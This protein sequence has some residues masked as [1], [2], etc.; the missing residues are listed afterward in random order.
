[1]TL[2]H[3]APR[4]ALL[5]LC[6]LAGGCAV[7][8]AYHRPDI[9]L[10]GPYRSVAPSITAGAPSLDTWWRGFDDPML[11]TV[12]ERA[13]AENLDIAQA[14]ARVLMSRAQAKA[15]GAALFP[16]GAF[17]AQGQSARQSLESPIGTIGR[18]L[19]GFKRDN[20]IADFGVGASWDP[21]LFGGL[22]RG[23]AA[24]RA[25]AG[26]EAAR[27]EAVRLAVVADTADA[28]IQVRAFQARLGVVA[29][30]EAT[31]GDLVELL[32]KQAG[33]GV[34]PERELRQTQA[35]LEGVRASIPPLKTGLEI[36]LNRLDVLMGARPGTW[37]EQLTKVA[38]IPSPPGLALGDGPADLLRRRP[39]IL[40]AEQR[41]VATNARIGQAMA[42]YYPKVT[43]SGLL[44]MESLDAS[45]LFTPDAIQAVGSGALKW[46][47]FDFGRVDAEVA[48]ARAA[49][50]EAL[51]TWRAV[52][53]RATE[54]VEDSVT[55]LVQQ[56]GRAVAL[57]RQ[58]AQLTVARRQA[59]QAYEGGVISLVEVREAD[60]DLL[61]AT[62]Q[63]AQTRAGAALAAVASFRALGGGWTP[64]ASRS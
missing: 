2:S 44:G 57:D 8:P 64:P 3:H 32:R 4:A 41:L 40:A 61:A 53:L 52:A 25:D 59:E 14:R 23:R 42:E 22:R 37:R 30:Q 63:L 56:Q 16:L 9:A 38:P 18:H 19:P 21:D 54:E 35:A 1:M 17:D 62:D 20:T 60:R 27:A 29:R 7:G 39:D 28:Y 47:L 13:Q 50:A 24:A 58:I 36:Q 10:A 43:V 48:G 55:D 11:V 46:R 15:A 34:A 26:V 45:R 5:S 49:D 51:A 31:Q 6:V 33:Q 12:I